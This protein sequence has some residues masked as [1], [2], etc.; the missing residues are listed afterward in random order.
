MSDNTYHNNSIL[1]I[2]PVCDS[3]KSTAGIVVLFFFALFMVH[4]AFNGVYIHDEAF[5]LTIPYRVFLGDSLLVDEWHA[6]QLSSFVQ[7]PLLWLFMKITGSTEGIILFFR[8]VYIFFQTAVSVCIFRAFRK[9][10]FTLA[11]IT[12]SVFLVSFAPILEAVNYFTASI[13][14]VVL[15]LLLLF[16]KE[17]RSRFSLLL[18][19]VL[20]SFAVVSEPTLAVFYLLFTVAVIV[21]IF[22]GKNKKTDKLLSVRSWIFITAGVSVVFVVFLF[23]LFSRESV[24]VVLS[25]LANVFRNGEYSGETLFTYGLIFKGLIQFRPLY[26]LYFIWVGF[27]LLLKKKTGVSG[28]KYL[29]SAGLI[30]LL[31]SFINVFIDVF[32]QHQFLGVFYLFYDGMMLTLG[33]GLLLKNR[34]KEYS[35][36]FVTGVLYTLCVGIYSQSLYYIGWLGALI[37]A[38]PLFPVA[39]DLMTEF[40]QPDNEQNKQD[41]NK[42]NTAVPVSPV[43]AFIDTKA[44]LLLAVFSG[45]FS[46]IFLV[47]SLCFLITGSIPREIMKTDNGDNVTVC[48]TGI[49]KGISFTSGQA[50]IYSDIMT[51]VKEIEAQTEGKYTVASQ[52]ETWLMLESERQPAVFTSWYAQSDIRT[53]ETY[54]EQ[55]GITPSA[56]YIPWVDFHTEKED[57]TTAMHA[58]IYFEKLFDCKTETGKAGYIVTIKGWKE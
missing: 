19:G 5:Y 38:M 23:Y 11:L 36:F 49:F 3:K 7:Y 34:K 58:L 46:L 33:F 1:R 35:A 14:A 24:N 13:F 18:S 45:I 20:L 29:A 48:E 8:F 6:S 2:N 12:A 37:S 55:T 27:I 52:N 26:F 32:A 40:R 25:S 50:K 53:F 31:I 17:K 44:S 10:G 51:D 42:G 47:F 57:K 4:A 43:K 56:V 15:I 16:V 21:N 41:N 30:I 54:Y 9:Y 22:A 39:A 28:R